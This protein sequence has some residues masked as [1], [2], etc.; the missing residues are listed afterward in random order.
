MI[1][2]GFQVMIFQ[3]IGA[4][5]EAAVSEAVAVVSTGSVSCGN[6]RE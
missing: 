4:E 3:W 5:C 6:S 1:W 2:F